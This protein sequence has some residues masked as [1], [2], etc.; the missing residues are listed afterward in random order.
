MSDVSDAMI[1]ARAEI[2]SS[3]PE[4]M[5]STCSLIPQIKADDGFSGHKLADDTANTI[6]NIPCDMEVVSGGFQIND[7]GS[8][9]TKSVRLRMP[10][11]AQTL[12]ITRNHNILIAASGLAPATRV[13]H[14]VKQ[15]GDKDVFLTVGASFVE[16]YGQP[17]MT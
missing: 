6:A 10:V 5:A 13:E 7:G 17:A 3:A 1:E 4:F 16:G 15:L 8:L 14:P 2:A 11:T 9:V 12:G